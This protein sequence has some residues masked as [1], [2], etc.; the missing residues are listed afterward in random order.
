MRDT[1]IPQASAPFIANSLAVLSSQSI[2]GWAPQNRGS[3]LSYAAEGITGPAFPYSSML[4]ALGN[5]RFSFARPS[6]SSPFH[7]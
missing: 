3:P 1:W 2:L 4:S 6:A 7:S 5:S